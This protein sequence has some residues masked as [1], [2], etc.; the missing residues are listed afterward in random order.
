MMT[1]EKRMRIHFRIIGS[2]LF[3]C[4]LFHPVSGR[5]EQKGA[6]EAVNRMNSTLMENMKRAQELGFSGRYKL[7]DPVIRDVF[8]LSYMS[9]KT[10]GGYWNTISQEQR[11]Q[12]LDLYTVWTISSYAGS[13]DGYAG[14]RFDTREGE[15]IKGDTA[16]VMSN[17]VIPHEDSVDFNYTLHRFQDKWRIVDIRTSG[18]S[19]LSLT[20]SQFVSVMKSKGFE[21]LMAALKEKIAFYHAK[22]MQ[23]K[24]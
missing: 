3:A 7:L 19:Q 23:G 2:L 9:E 5:G 1:F 12:Y 22:D 11:K 18:V 24:K 6:A 16:I 15:Q 17:L 20:R 8:A 4:L 14:E 13:F 10:L 21:G